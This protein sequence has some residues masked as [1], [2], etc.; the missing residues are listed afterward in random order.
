MAA[1][2]AAAETDR[3][4]TAAECAKSHIKTQ[5]YKVY[6]KNNVTKP[7]LTPTNYTML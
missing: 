7:K 4:Q 1:I 2:L 3:G 6:A 5:K